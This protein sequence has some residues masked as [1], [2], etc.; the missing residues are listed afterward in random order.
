MKAYWDA[1]ARE[2]AMYYIHS[3]LNYASTNEEEFWASGTDTLDRC[4]EPFGA[5]I[6]ADDVVVEIGCGIGRVTRPIAGRA[7][8]VVGIDVSAEMIDKGRQALA[9]LANVELLVGNGRDL[10]DIGTASADVVYSFIVF[11]HIPDPAITCNY[12]RE[13]GRVLRPGG[14]T[15]FQVS[16]LPALHQPETYAANKGLRKGMQRML[17]KAPKGC[18]APEWLG[19]AVSRPDLLAAL[20]AGGL[21]VQKIIGDGTQYCVIHAVKPAA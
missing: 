17:G 11:Q 2:N 9:D 14:W 21:H 10:S 13:I 1:K 7:A 18:L 4:L 12:I 19:S 8:R 16:D 6:T 5:A 15:I 3:C 20:G